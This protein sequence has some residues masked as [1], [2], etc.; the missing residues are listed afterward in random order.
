MHQFYSPDIEKTLTL[1]PEESQHAVRVLRLSGGDEIEV[2][3]GKG[4]RYK[5]RI[6]MAHQKHCNVEIIESIPEPNHWSCNI[7][8]GVAPTKN[9]DR[10]E[11]MVEKCT[12]AGINRIIPVKCRYSE[13]KELK[14]ER[15][16]KILVSAM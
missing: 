9:L 2:V 12:E 6:T 1:S 5:C 7:I 10:I 4:M 8:I 3:D 16:K 14:T 15:I 11:W 13:R